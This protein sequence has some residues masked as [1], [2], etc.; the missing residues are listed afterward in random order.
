VKE[1]YKIILF[2]GLNYSLF[3]QGYVCAVGGG[4]ENYYD[5]SDKPYGW[6]VQKADS[7]KIIIISDTDASAW[8]PNYFMWLGADTAY[9]KTIASIS[10][11]NLQSTYDELITAK[12]IFIR[13]G[14]QWDYIR[15]WKET[16]TDSAVNHVFQNG[17]V[18]AGTSAGAAV[19]GDVDFSAKNGSAYPDEALLNPFYNRMQFESNFLNLIPDVLFDTHFIQRGRHGRLIAMLYNQH[20]SAGRDLIGIGV[21]DRTAFCISPDGIGE[22]MGSGAASV[23]QIDSE[24][25]LE[26]INSGNYLIGGLKCDQL[27]NGWKYDILNKQIAFIPASAQQI[28]I[29]R[30]WQLP[31]TNFWITGSENISEHLG[32][33]FTNY[34]LSNNTSFVTIISHPGYL[35]QLA[36]IIDY[37]NQINLIYEVLYLTNSNQN[38]LN[39]VQ[40]ISNSTCFVF[41]GDSLSVFA[42]LKDST[43][44]AGQSFKQKI[45]TQKTP[46]FFFGKTG[47]IIGVSY[48]DNLYTDVY[49]SYRGKITNN[50]GLNLFSDAL[51]ETSIFTDDDYY[52]NKV[53]SVLWGMMRN[54][55]R[56]GI[57]LHGDAMIVT[58]SEH[59]TIKGYGSLP[60]IFVDA[61]K[62]TFVDSS[63]YRASSSVGPRQVVA[64][65]NLRYSISTYDGIEYLIEQAKFTTETSVKASDSSIPSNYILYQNY[66]N[67]FNPSTTISWHTSTGSWQVLKVYDLLGNEIGTLLDQYLPAGNHKVEFYKTNKISS[68]I[69]FYTIFTSQYTETK[70]MVL[71]K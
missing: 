40:V 65:N 70:S 62:T 18:I 47:K 32:N 1:I 5:W 30:S 21:D 35:V 55:K 36:P 46:A 31:T 38:S 20:F 54:R 64:M 28:D 23:F 7:G 10:D 25:I 19:L 42:L 13:G 3:A 26:T 48:T 39:V 66:P 15:V 43:S 29:L 49:A 67:P 24:T 53:S 4:S 52:E 63:T 45:I 58:D 33:S 57:Y 22:V 17:G 2:L 27:V 14:D 16:K 50:S 34:I 51:V 11:A 68:G 69:Y 56:L 71:L 61:S 9:N 8:L 37:L 60:P 41:A 6:I 44:L 59:K 12:A